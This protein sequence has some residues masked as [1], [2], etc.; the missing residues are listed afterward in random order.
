[1]WL[2]YYAVTVNVTVD[3]FCPAALSF[4]LS[5]EMVTANVSPSSL[6]DI[7]KRSTPYA[8]DH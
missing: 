1:M 5:K 4:N 3:V 6:F 7:L 8:V 2:L